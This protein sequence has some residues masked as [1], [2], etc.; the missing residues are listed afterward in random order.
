MI[1]KYKTSIKNAQ[2]K[3]EIIGKSKLKIKKLPYMIVIDQKRKEY[4]KIFDV[5]NY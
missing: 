1:D 2:D 4:S 3:K 5:M